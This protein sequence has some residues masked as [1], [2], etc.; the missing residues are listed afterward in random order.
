MKSEQP[1]P[2]PP[3]AASPPREIIQPP[4]QSILAMATSLPVASCVARDYTLTVRSL[5]ATAGRR[6]AQCEERRRIEAGKKI[7]K[8]VRIL[9]C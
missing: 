5:R 9:L 6:A 8:V 4:T 7:L 3:V 2:P 1:P